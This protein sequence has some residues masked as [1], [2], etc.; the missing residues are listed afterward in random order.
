M[1]CTVL[2]NV[3]SVL[4]VLLKVWFPYGPRGMLRLRWVDSGRRVFPR[5]LPPHFSFY[6]YRW[7][8]CSNTPHIRMYIH[9][10]LWQ[11]ESWPGQIVPTTQEHTYL[12]Y[13]PLFSRLLQHDCT[14]K[15]YT[16]VTLF[17]PPP[18]TRCLSVDVRIPRPCRASPPH[19][20]SLPSMNRWWLHIFPPLRNVERGKYLFFFA[21][22][23]FIFLA[24]L[25][26]PQRVMLALLFYSLPFFA[27]RFSSLLFF[28]RF[29]RGQ[30]FREVAAS[31]ERGG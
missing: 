13:P 28:S 11:D 18:T 22:R 20:D 31:G 29:F 4:L 12:L 19:T 30:L 10:G 14:R 3:K 6:D 21:C 23:S 27:F 1:P 9:L 2:S 7:S 15:Y 24:T 5:C 26:L 25:V 8:P 16:G 17:L